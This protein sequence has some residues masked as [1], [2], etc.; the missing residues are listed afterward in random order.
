MDRLVAMEAFV[1]AADGRSFSQA[2]RQMRLSKSVVSRQIAA[3]E[4]AL[5][6][7]LLQRTTRTLT[8]TEAGRLYLERARRVLAEVEDAERS[9]GQLSDAPRGQLRVSAPMS[10]GFL[11]LAAAIPAFLARHPD[12]TVDMSLTDRF[13][14][15]VEEG[16]DVAVRI[17]RLRDSSLVARRLAPS[18]LVVCG[19]PGYLARRGVPRVPADL[20]GHECLHN[21]NIEGQ[22]AF[23][24]PDGGVQMVDVSGRLS[25]NNGDALQAAAR[26][27]AGLVYLPSFIVGEDLQAGRLVSV[28]DGF[29]TV[30]AT[31]N[32]VYPHARHLSPKVRVFV[33]F[34][35]ERFGPEPYWDRPA[36]T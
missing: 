22:W 35:A 24:L 16:F 5:G 2:A 20:A 4:A 7:R 29:T 6:A 11:H 34:L 27:G 26:E 14:D 18:R 33:D 3:L 13:V 36:A 10:F 1:R 31:V 21:T 25:A 15:L 17:G 30:G 23:A 12:V 9:V 28:L 8:L 19:S 32:A